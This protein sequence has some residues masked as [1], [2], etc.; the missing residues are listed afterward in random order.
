LYNTNRFIWRSNEIL[1]LVSGAGFVTAA[2]QE[3]KRQHA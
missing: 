2:L 3:T 1:L